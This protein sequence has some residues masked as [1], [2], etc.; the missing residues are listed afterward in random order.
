TH[1]W[2]PELL[3]VLDLEPARLSALAAMELACL[4]LQ[5]AFADRWP[6]LGK[7]PWLPAVGDGACSNVGAGCTMRNRAALMIGTSGAMRVLWRSSDLLIP[8]GAWC[9]HA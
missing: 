5:P 1:T 2:D 4:G 3:A 7:V 6:Q 9:Y 8:W